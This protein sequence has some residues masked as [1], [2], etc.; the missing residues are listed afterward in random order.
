LV[1]AP[2]AGVERR[3]VFDLPPMTVRV[4][5]HQ[6]IA[7]RCCC[8]VTTCADAP[9][10][11]TA[12]VQYG[13]RITAII[14]SLYVGQFLS[15]NRTA[16]ALAELFGTP[17]SE[18][19]EAAMTRRAADKLADFLVRVTDRLAE[20]EVTGFDETGLRVAGSLHWVHCP[21][22]DKYTL[23]T[24]HAKRGR[25]GIDAAGVLGRFHGV[26]VHDPGRHMTPTS[27]PS[28]N[29][30][31]PT[32]CASWPVSPKPSRSRPTGAGPPR[33]PTRSSRCNTW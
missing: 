16:Q 1:G 13:Q 2:Q 20:A 9:A 26:A 32:P 17:V 8:G 27:T 4:A 10:G 18:G 24:C 7:R 19:I 11:V 28:T 12:P 33:S 31:A 14:L 29:C 23:I 15:K 30:A 3:Q 25:K 21:R 6:L 5:E 22:T